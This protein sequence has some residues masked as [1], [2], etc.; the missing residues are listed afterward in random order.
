VR[1]VTLFVPLEAE[2][3][4]ALDRLSA[5]EG[6]TAVVLRRSLDARKGRP[7]GH[8]L[9]V[10]LVAPGEA[11][12]AE[13]LPPPARARAGL[14]VVVVGAGPAGTFC[15]MRLQQAGA[16]VTLVEQGKPVQPRRR[17]LASLTQR[18]ELDPFSNY[19][20]G[21]GG[22]G[23]FS[24]GKLYT[25]TK[26]RLG[27]RSV[28]RALVAH[29]AD[30]GILVESRPHVGSNKL[31]RILTAMREAL[32]AAGVVYLFSEAVV[33]LLAEG[34]RVRGAV[35]ASGREL[36]A[37]A[38]VLAVGHSARPLYALLER[39]GVALEAKPF[40]LGARI[41]HPQ[42][43]IDRLQ[44]G[45]AAG[46]P[47]LPAAFYEVAA[48]VPVPDAG[49]R[50]VYSFCMCPGGWI[51]DAATEPDHLCTNGMSLSRRDSPHANAALVVTVEPRDYL[52]RFGA[53]PL[54][55]LALQRQVE[56][57]AFENGGGGFVAPTQ[58]VAD[59]LASRP[60]ESALPTSY[61]PG[62]RPGD[63]RSALPPFIA[64]A[65]ARALSVFER[66]L[67][68]FSR[69]AAQ[70][71]GVETRTSSPVRILRGRDLASPSHR[72][73]Y[74]A[75]EGA[76]YAGGIVSAALDGL[77]IADAILSSSLT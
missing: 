30:P 26:D 13:E 60:S 50:G 6:G 53:G 75:G 18:G 9:D 41:E 45:R 8:H 77:R 16:A 32:E 1:R 61:R 31:P 19:C 28:L 67:P 5:R 10:A 39:R 14:R 23:T 15:A 54:A 69:G 59:F 66:K 4:E 49:E 76:G 46:H 2:E 3:Q 58:L 17:D 35:T 51:V 11:A 52:G 70:L 72:G 65:M 38:T 37:D 55:G 73:L 25:R 24:D 21:E 40:A 36:V 62:T 44:Y 48:T 43:L 34:D 12:P 27:V 42:P 20:F 74:P 47:K 57:R 22:A 56:R 64:E 71:I 29:G 63:V 33:D 7:V 68:G